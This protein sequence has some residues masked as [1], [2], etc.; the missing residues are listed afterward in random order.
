MVTGSYGVVL[1][2]DTSFSL[3]GQTTITL[4]VTRP[5]GSSFSVTPTVGS[6]DITIEGHAFT[7]NEYWTYTTLDGQFPVTGN[8]KLKLTVQFDVPKRLKSKKALLF[9]DA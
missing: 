8:Y 5:D 2:A 9:V 7:A 6:S 3:V 4:D 1:Y